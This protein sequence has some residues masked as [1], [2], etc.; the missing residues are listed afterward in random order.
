MSQ[1]F[2]SFKREDELRVSRLVKA[3]EGVGLSVWWDRGLAGGES[4]RNQIQGAL[5]AAKCVIVVW[6]HE[7][8]GPAG[9]F[10]R[11]EAGQAKRRGVLLPVRLDKVEPPLGFGEIQVIDLTGWKGSSRDPFFQDLLA[12]V[13]AKLE[14]RAV[15]AAKGPMKRL[16]RGLTYS[17]AA[18]AL[19]LGIGAFGS[20]MWR[21]Q[22]HICGAPLFQPYISDVCGALGL[23]DRP[24]REERIAWARR[25]RG[26]CAA[27]RLHIEHFPKGAY[28]AEATSLLAARRATEYE[29]WTPMTRRLALFQPQEYPASSSEA[30]A[31]SVALIS[32][33][34]RAERLCRGFAATTSFRLRSAAPEAEKW[35]CDSG[36]AGVACTFEG[37]A[38]CELDE[39]AVVENETCGK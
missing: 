5:D 2:I 3:L 13:A 24:A 19:L 9:D 37:E 18:G 34:G 17:S 25:E 12:A 16:M 22:D 23:G 8:V 4:W 36:A 7:S 26:S 1:I 27:L 28:R 32:A 30:K 29:V 20:N 35:N 14:G 38:V 31:R 15:P 33:Q 11:D 6:T 10:V 21:L 39:R